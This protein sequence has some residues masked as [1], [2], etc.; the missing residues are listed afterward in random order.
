MTSEDFGLLVAFQE[1][2]PMGPAQLMPALAEI[3]A[4]L[5]NGPLKPPDSRPSWSSR[6]FWSALTAWAPQKPAPTDDPRGFLAKLR[7]KR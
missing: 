1:V 5:A 4:A 7:G 2:E 6:D 3:L